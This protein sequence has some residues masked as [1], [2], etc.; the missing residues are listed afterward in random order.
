MKTVTFIAIVLLALPVA[1]KEDDAYLRDFEERHQALE[2]VQGLI[3][4]GRLNEAEKAIGG[5]ELRFAK[6]SNADTFRYSPRIEIGDAYFERGEP[7]EAIR[8]F[9]SASP[10][11]W[12]GNCLASQRV[13]KSVRIAMVHQSQLNFPAAFASY[14]GALPST[15]LGGGL[16]RIIAG[17]LYAGTVTIAPF[18]VAGYFLAR[19][20]RGRKPINTVVERHESPSPP[21]E[22]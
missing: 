7:T 17:L 18:G 22:V 14:L 11:G 15:A 9:R 1:A 10:A 13:E 2:D 12:C 6:T 20:M 4:A 16:F 8:L 19:S 5:Y 21:E 3:R